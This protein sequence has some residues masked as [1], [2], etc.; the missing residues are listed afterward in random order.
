VKL[1]NP[2]YWRRDEEIESMRRSFEGR[3]RLTSSRSTVAA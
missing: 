1:K 3:G 2:D